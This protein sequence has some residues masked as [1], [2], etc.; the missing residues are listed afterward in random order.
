[1]KKLIQQV[2]EQSGSIYQLWAE[3]TDCL[4][5][6]GYKSLKFT[7]V[8]T[9]SKDPDKPWVKGQFFL[10]PEAFDNLKELLNTDVDTEVLSVYNE[11][12]L[13]SKYDK[14]NLKGV[15]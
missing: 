9:G 14:E 2:D 6:E 1:M 5:P 8:Y 4:R 10:S 12:R 11:E 3:V 13:V 7:S 15:K